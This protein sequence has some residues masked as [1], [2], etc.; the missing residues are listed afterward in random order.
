[1]IFQSDSLS[2]LYSVPPQNPWAPGWE[3]AAALI[4]GLATVTGLWVGFRSVRLVEKD[5]TLQRELQ[6]QDLLTD[7]L[8][9]A[10][11]YVFEVYRASLVFVSDW[12]AARKYLHGNEDLGVEFV[13]QHEAG[14]IREFQSRWEEFER[15]ITATMFLVENFGPREAELYAQ[16]DHLFQTMARLHTFAHEQKHR[17]KPDFA[18]M[19]EEE[20]INDDD[21]KNQKE[22]TRALEVAKKV[23][24]LARRLGELHPHTFVTDAPRV[25]KA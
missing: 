1:M 15:Q 9:K 17:T 16:L 7:E 3:A 14:L 19:S 4:A 8:R 13:T 10:L 6:R 18:W 11:L 24:A 22:T 2:L 25:A 20:F 23:G 12:R 21:F 5:L